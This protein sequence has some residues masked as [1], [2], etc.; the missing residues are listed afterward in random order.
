MVEAEDAAIDDVV[1]LWQLVPCVSSVDWLAVNTKGLSLVLQDPNVVVVLVGVQGNLLLQASGGVHEGVRVKIATLSVDMADADSASHDDIGGDISHALAVQSSLEFGAHESIA[2][3]RVGQ[4]E[5]VDGEH[6]EIEGS[7]EDDEA[8][9]SSHEVL[10]P[11]TLRNR[12][13][14]VNVLMPMGSKKA[15]REK[16][17]KIRT[18]ETFLLSP[19]RTHSWTRVKDPTHAMVNRPTHLMLAVM[20]KPRPDMASQNHQL[21]WNALSGPCSC[22]LVKQENDMAVNAVAKTRGESRRIRRA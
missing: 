11:K 14:L 12:V 6:G 22:W 10:E 21:S 2:L 20:P 16:V 19:R 13:A 5:E 3:A 1:Y 7:G 9:Y 17:S 8:E 15:E 18:T 4:A